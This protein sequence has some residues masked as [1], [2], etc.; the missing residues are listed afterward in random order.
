M[1]KSADLENVYTI[2][3]CSSGLCLEVIK[4]RT[5]ELHHHKNKD[6]QKFKLNL[7]SSERM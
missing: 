7:L 6:A 1:I 5:L 4:D 2:Y 3:H